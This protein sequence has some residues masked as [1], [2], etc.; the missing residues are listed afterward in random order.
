ML[1]DEN[2]MNPMGERRS[3]R[4]RGEVAR[5]VRNHNGSPLGTPW[6]GGAERGVRLSLGRLRLLFITGG[7]KEC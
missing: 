2:E 3:W 1:S 6:V 4:R 7:N 5:G